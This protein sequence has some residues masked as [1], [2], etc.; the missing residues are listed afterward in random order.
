MDQR[1]NALISC[2]RT[3]TDREDIVDA[4]AQLARDGVE[5]VIVSSVVNFSD[6]ATVTSPLPP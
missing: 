2:R 5:T 1:A 4:A 6:N 3:L